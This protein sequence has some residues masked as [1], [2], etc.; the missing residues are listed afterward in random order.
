M[1][2]KS[3]TGIWR[4]RPNPRMI[5]ASVLVV[6]SGSGLF[7]CAASDAANRYYITER[8]EPREPSSVEVLRSPPQRPHTV[9][10]DFQA[11]SVSVDYM[12][13]EAAKIG[14]DA[15]IVTLLG[16]TAG[17]EQEWASDDRYSTT[18]TRMTGTAI[19]YK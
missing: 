2:V 14:A 8:F 10:A 17:R 13:K 4:V 15:V 1:E 5:L 7:G 12:R 11:R 18:Y 9:M 16:G 6:S 3:L 19:R